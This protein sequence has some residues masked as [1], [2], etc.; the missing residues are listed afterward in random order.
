MPLLVEKYRPT[1]L[2]DIVGFIPSFDIDDSMPHLLLYGPPGT[3]KTTL[4]K[5][6]IRK[7]NCDHIILNASSERGIDVIRDKVKDFASTKSKDSNIKIIFLDEADHLTPD[8]Q[9]ALRNTIETYSR[10]TRFILTCNY[11]NRIIDPLKSR[12]VSI[13]FDNLPADLIVNRL[14]FICE[15][16]KIPYELE[17]LKKIVS[18]TKSDIRSA[19]NKIEEFKDGVLL[20]KIISN[21]NIAMTVYQYIQK[22]DFISARQVILDSHPDYDQL[23]LD[24]N[25]IIFSNSIS[26]DS[27]M[28]SI[29]IIADTYKWLNQ[30]AIK[31]ILIESMIAQLIGVQS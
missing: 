21:N 25:N 8:A 22:K 10:N 7:L 9:T 15:Q 20:S 13:K 18:I 19:I 27:K 2:K 4:A 6:I 26:I 17:A 31:E 23:I 11:I 24:L 3:G 30:V 12:C 29:V 28:K 16:E 5:V 1:E 14:I